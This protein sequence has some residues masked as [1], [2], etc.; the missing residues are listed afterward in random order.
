ML[1]KVK[2]K[3]TLRAAAAAIIVAAVCAAADDA[4]PMAACD[5]SFSTCTNRCDTMENATAEC[6]SACDNAYQKCLNIANGYPPE[7]EQKANEP[8]KTA[9]PLKKP[10]KD[11]PALESQDEGADPDRPSHKQ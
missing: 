9:A 8:K 10:E 7:A 5:N 6:Y 1:L 4:D 3:V 11:T 2:T